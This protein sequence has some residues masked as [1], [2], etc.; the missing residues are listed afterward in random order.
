M[1]QY[2]N[3]DSTVE[4]MFSVAQS[5]GVFIIRDYLSGDKLTKLTPLFIIFSIS[6]VPI[7]L[8]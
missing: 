1:I 6:R 4:Q 2:L 5:D 8:S 3:K 7:A